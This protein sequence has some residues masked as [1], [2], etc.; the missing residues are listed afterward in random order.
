MV[1]SL[2]EITKHDFEE[3]CTLPLPDEQ[4]KHLADNGISLLESHYDE[5]VTPRAVYLDDKPVGFIMWAKATGNKVVIYRFM[6]TIEYQNRGIGRKALYLAFDEIKTDKNIELIEICYS[7]D[8]VPAKGL[9]ASVGFVEAGMDENN[10]DMLAVIEVARQAD[11][12]SGAGSSSVELNENSTISTEASLE[13]LYGKANPTSLAKEAAQLNSAYQQWIESAPFMAIASVGSGGL[14]CSPRGDEV[15]LLFRV[16][17]EKTIAIPDRAGNNRLDTLRNIVND[18]RVALLFLI[19]GIK[20]TLRINGT[21]VIETDESL[22]DS[23]AV[24]GKKPV[25]VVVVT[26]QSIY[27]QCGRAMLRSKLWDP[28]QQITAE[29]VPT[30]GQ[31]LQSVKSDFDGGAYDANLLDRQKSSLY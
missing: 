25:T 3:V 30:A 12:K 15:G 22:L 26:I 2:R 24:S 11:V 13:N 31:M 4:Y 6:V 17:D 10:E 14:D 27:F 5:S 28:K 7:V 18:P 19:P 1:V 8:N 9:Y 23:F 21:A 16:L 29:S 20:E